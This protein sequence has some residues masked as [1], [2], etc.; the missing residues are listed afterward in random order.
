MA[1]YRPY[2]STPAPTPTPAQAHRTHRN[3]NLSCGLCLDAQA[4]KSAGM[5]EQAR[6]ATARTMRTAPGF[7]R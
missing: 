2:V 5:I 3:Y 6:N 7:A 4:E 1:Q